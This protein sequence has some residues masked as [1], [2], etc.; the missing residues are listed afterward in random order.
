MGKSMGPQI[1]ERGRIVLPRRLREKFG[2]IPGMHIRIEVTETG[3]LLRPEK[4]IE[5]A[6]GRLRGIIH[7][8]NRDPQAPR[9]DPLDVK[10]IWEPK[11]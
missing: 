11:L 4:D 3:I 9:T 7:S 6:I 1:D 5:E 10:K 2:L 8:G